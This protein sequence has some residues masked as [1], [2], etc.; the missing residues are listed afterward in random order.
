MLEIDADNKLADDANVF[1]RYLYTADA[2]DKHYS[3]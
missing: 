3:K 2:L 1:I